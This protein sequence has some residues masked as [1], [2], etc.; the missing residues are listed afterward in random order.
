[1]AFDN[2]GT[3]AVGAARLGTTP[4]RCE[5]QLFLAGIRQAIRR[6]KALNLGRLNMQF[7]QN[8]PKD[9]KITALLIFWLKTCKNFAR[10]SFMV[11]L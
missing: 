8:W 6:F 4:K 7:Q 10:L 5:L 1:M 2:S 11:C 9:K 3:N